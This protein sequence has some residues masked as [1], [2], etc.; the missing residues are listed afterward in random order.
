MRRTGSHLSQ[1]TTD[2]RA[3]AL[4]SPKLSATSISGASQ[5]RPPR[6]HDIMR[7]DRL[8]LASASPFRRSAATGRRRVGE[9]A[10]APCSNRTNC[11]IAGLDDGALAAKR[12]CRTGDLDSDV[13]ATLVFAMNQSLDLY[14]DHEAMAPGPV[15]FRHWIEHVRGL[16]GSVYGRRLYEVMR[17]WD[18]RIRTPPA[19]VNALQSA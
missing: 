11:D 4:R 5:G 3:H 10:R 16:A 12:C 14:V 8:K 9:A 15:L 13:V 18:T 2:Y 1:A 7:L 17:Y 6:C 19:S